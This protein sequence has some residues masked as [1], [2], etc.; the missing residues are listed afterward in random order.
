MSALS[1]STRPF[2]RCSAIALLAAAI[3]CPVGAQTFGDEVN[4]SNTAL[5]AG[6]L[7]VAVVSPNV[8]V[9]WRET[10]GKALFSR[11]TNSGQT[12]STPI[13][14]FKVATSGQGNPL[15]AAS[16]SNVYVVRS[17]SPKPNQPR[18]IFFKRSTNSGASFGNQVQVSSASFGAGGESM[19]ISGASVYLCWLQ[20]VGSY[21]DVFVARSTDGGASFSAPVNLSNTP[22]DAQDLVL[23]AEGSGVHVAWTEGSSP[24]REIFYIGSTD[25]GVSFGNVIN[26]SNSAADGWGPAIAVSGL[27]AY[28]SWVEAKIRFAVSTNGGMTFSAP[29]DLSV[30]TLGNAQ[31]PRVAASGN[32]V[33]VIWG[34]DSPGNDDIFH[35][36]STDGG[37]IFGAESNLSFSPTHSRDG[38]VAVNGTNVS[39]A[40]AE[41]GEI[42]LVHSGND[43]AT[44][45]AAVNVSTSS[46]GSGGPTIT[47]PTPTEIHAT[48]L[49]STPGNTDVFFARGMVP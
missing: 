4:V 43:G 45:G 18:Q 12:F 28:L 2:I 39:I 22:G 24:T 11:S 49:D 36:A 7:S 48:W 41:A 37:V 19:A 21:N 5:D 27:N 20:R 26:V 23:A 35:R 15:V 16:G 46:G 38:F 10:G 34:S 47:M 6:S 8:Y 13:Q 31:K 1:S 3:G 44:F 33:Q 30:G 29:V 32:A 25:G 14:I 42:F 17:A 9:V 40:W